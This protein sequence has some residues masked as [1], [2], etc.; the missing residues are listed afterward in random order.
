MKLQTNLRYNIKQNWKQI[1]PPGWKLLKAWNLCPSIYPTPQ[2]KLPK[3]KSSLSFLHTK[4]KL[5]FRKNLF[6]H[7]ILSKSRNSIPKGRYTIMA[8]NKMPQLLN[9]YHLGCTGLRLNRKTVCCYTFFLQSRKGNLVPV[10]LL[11]YSLCTSQKTLLPSTDLHCSQVH[12]FYQIKILARFVTFITIAP[13][14]KPRYLSH[15]RVSQT[16]SPLNIILFDFFVSEKSFPSIF[17]F[18]FSAH[19][20]GQM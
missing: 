12:H 7:V 6:C 9:Q 5:Q 15:T 13:F 17:S 19:F 4:W 3:G 8:L 14:M 1:S 11:Q 2:L 16:P 10:S 18:E 20:I